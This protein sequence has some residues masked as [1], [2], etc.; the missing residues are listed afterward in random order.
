[1]DASLEELALLANTAGLEVAGS[2]HQRLPAPNPTY[3]LGRGKV[4]ELRE[5]KDPWRY[6]VVLV[7][8]ELSPAQQRN[9]EQALS[10]PVLD[11]SALILEI[12]GQHA[13]TLEGRLQVEF[14]R[15][16]YLLPR[17][18]GRW[19][20]LSRQYGRLG[21]RGGPG[22]T[23]IEMD[24]RRV[25]QRIQLLKKRIQRV[26]EHRAR[27]RERR[28]ERGMPVVALVGYTNAGKTTL[29]NT[30]TKAQGH[31][32]DKLF[33]TLDPLARRFILPSGRAALLTDTVGFIQKLPTTLVAAFRAT[34]EELGDAEVLLHVVDITHPQAFAQTTTVTQVLQQLGL[35]EKPIVTALNKVDK[36]LFPTTTPDAAAMTEDD[37]QRD[38][39]AKT[40][41]QLSQL[42]PSGVAVSALTGLGLAELR[43]R[44]EEVLARA[45][46]GKAPKVLAASVAQPATSSSARD[47][48]QPALPFGFGTT[49]RTPANLT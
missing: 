15:Y 33:A 5:L 44:V 29:M 48:P 32:A 13:N 16:E 31:T 41:E 47:V 17:L 12:F 20:H 21:A 36:A 2:L 28:K 7:D 37:R 38:E 4:D 8:D 19:P 11:R 26:R 18:A 49:R 40:L 9:L 35:Q 46:E 39:I 3:Y 14:A 6:D 10:T 27:Y 43:Q 45:L 23:Q 24:R 34:L 1:M 22:E 30:L 25:R 42:Y